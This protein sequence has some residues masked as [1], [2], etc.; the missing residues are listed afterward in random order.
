MSHDS[1]AP[2]PRAVASQRRARDRMIR[3]GRV[4]LFSTALF[5]A[6][7]SAQ[8]DSPVQ[9]RGFIDKQAGG[10]QN[11]RVPATDADIPLPRQADGSVNPRFRTTE[12][13]RFLGKQLFHDPIR[14][15]RIN[16]AYGGIPSTRQTASCGSCHLG[17]AAGKAGAQFNFAVG[18]EGRGYTD[19][20]GN[21]IVRRRPRADLPILRNSPLYNGDV[22][23]DELPTLTDIY[24]IPV[25]APG[26]I[27]VTTPARGR[28]TPTPSALLRT[29]RLDALDSVG[30]QS[31]GMIGFAFNN[32]LLLGGFGGEPDSVRGALNPFG[33]PAQ[34]NLTLLLLDAH[35]ML[36]AEGAVLQQIPAY[37]RLFRE[38]FPEEAAKADAARN[39]DMLVNDETVFRATATFLRTV[40]TRNTP[41]DRFIAGDNNALTPAQ[42]RGA[43]MF[44]TP[45]T[46]G[47]AGCYSCHSGPM[48]NKQANDPDVLGVGQF[49]EENFINV[50]I[51]DHPL[52]A[53]GRLARNDPNFRDDGRREI[54]GRD[55]DA[56]K[57]RSLTL[58]QLRDART[59]F[60]N[61]SF[62]TVRSVVEYFNNGM[63]QDP[64]AGASPT[65]S[66]RF[67]FPRGPGSPRGLG[68][69]ASQIDDITDFIE[70]GLYDPAFATYDENSTTPFFELSERDTTYSRWRP[71]LAALGVRDGFPISGLAPNN[72]DPLSR[73]DQ[74]LE[75]LD[76][77]PSVAWERRGV[78]TRGI[79]QTDE[80]RLWNRGN[81]TV[82]THLLV[83]VRGLPPQ[84]RL[85]NANGATRSGDPY[86]RVFLRDGV[87]EPGQEFMQR[88]VL[89]RPAGGSA[90]PVSYTLDF[91]SGQGNP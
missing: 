45:A 26:V 15:A 44:F 83:I 8:S 21:F 19:E 34:E 75:F 10:L 13:K 73:R 3:T 53:L 80:I 87:L 11:L 23:V 72:N 85:D 22:G 20:N 38:A 17:E 65:L 51:G 78:Q 28:R 55:S 84:V 52:Q 37:V 76:V 56:F 61:G 42:R 39:L 77:T 40:V 86:I 88:I 63:P 43:R 68:L 30:R 58:R 71:D 18:A 47:G 50:G 48:L 82:D 90:A 64:V 4:I 12:A 16:P 49:I 31:P 81:S 27:E 32:R 1:F 69:T 2:F 59:F 62:T 5:S 14:T 74:G 36:E 91:L 9:L 54:T 41:F 66:T 79:R 57:F 29:G 6:V 7:A 89:S 25:P 67:T 35:R 46:E 33:D 60:H 70:N 24:Q